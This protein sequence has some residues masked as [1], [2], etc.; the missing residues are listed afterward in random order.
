MQSLTAKSAPDHSESNFD[1]AIEPLSVLEVSY[2]RLREAILAGVFRPGEH[3]RQEVIAARFKISRGPAR[4]ALNRLAAEGLV[5]LRPRRGYVVTTL[6]VSEVED[7]F[8]LRMTLEA[9][10]AA[11]AATRR[12][13][14]DIAEV[15]EILKRLESLDLTESGDIDRFT[16]LNRQFHERIYQC[17]GRP[18]LCKMLIALRNSVEHYIRFSL[19]PH[20]NSSN[21]H[22]IIFYYFS[23]GDS[24]AIAR[25]SAEHCR[26]IGAELIKKISK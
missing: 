10:A 15:E 19:F 12:T 26:K 13:S 11:L 7:I 25:A 4:E 23:I 5:E 3:L 20:N 21:D 1:E 16:T 22:R 6:D 24:D 17:S 14:Q 8:D 9:K 18:H 2:R